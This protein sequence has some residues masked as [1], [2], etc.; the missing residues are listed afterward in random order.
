MKTKLF[1]EFNSEFNRQMFSA[2]RN[3]WT[4]IFN[5]QS[6]KDFTLIGNVKMG[7]FVYD[8]ILLTS[9]DVFIVEFKRNAPGAIYI[10]DSGWASPEGLICAG[11]H[12]AKNSWEQMLEKR[13]ILYG[14]FR[15]KGLHNMFIKTIILFEKPFDLVRGNTIFNFENHKWFLTADVSNVA[16][17]LRQN[18]S[19]S[20]PVDFLKKTSSIFPCLLK[21]KLEERSGGM[22]RNI[23]H[24]IRELLKKV[25]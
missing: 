20:A 8:A 2:L 1:G 15:K 11:Y 24:I 9:T 7:S 3:Q 23:C 5:S 12:G 17:V 13:N 10:N 4:G 16:L 6:C 14:L 21:K 19:P 25:A 18:T 22:V